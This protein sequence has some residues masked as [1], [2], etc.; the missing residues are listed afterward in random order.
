MFKFSIKSGVM[1]RTGR[2]ACPFYFRVSYCGNRVSLYPG[3]GVDRIEDWDTKNGRV[4]RTAMNA[5]FVNS[6]ILADTA[7]L[8]KLMVSYSIN[9]PESAPEPKELRRAFLSAIGRPDADGD[10]AHK[11]QF[12][13]IYDDFMRDM[14]ARN[15]WTEASYRKFRNLKRHITEWLGREP[16]FSDF[17]EEGLLSFVQYF[18]SLGFRNTSIVKTMSF[19]KYFLRWCV[20]RGHLDKTAADDFKPKLKGTTIE[21]KEVI[22]LSFE[23]LM[24]LLRFDF[25]KRHNLAHVRDV[26]LFCSFSGLRYSDVKKLKRSDI[27]PDLSCIKVVTQK[28]TAALTIE[29][30]KYSREIL[31]RYAGQS[32]PADAA[33]PVLSNQRYNRLL[34]EAA[35]VAGIDTPQRIVYFKRNKR[36]EEVHPKYAIITTHAA[37]RSFV[38]NAL[39]LGIAPS[40]IM[41]WTGHSDYNSMK[42]YIKI[43]DELKKESMSRF[44]T[45]GGQ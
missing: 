17:G 30:N 26:F 9:N 23:E 12:W 29:L 5:E 22:Y 44:D 13:D 14:G 4:A 34:K 33:L 28:T 10:K 32:L 3:Y 41:Q 45:F 31:Q 7:A 43:V 18:H 19:T 15:E 27:S 38:V 36:I 8:N 16:D 20:K 21:S 42:P 40:V 24:R 1:K 35:M 6:Q 2:T 25:G 11:R 37:R 39:R